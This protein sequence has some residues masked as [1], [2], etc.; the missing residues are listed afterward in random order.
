MSRTGAMKMDFSMNIGYYFRGGLWRNNVKEVIFQNA[1]CNQ[2][3]SYK[4]LATLNFT[5]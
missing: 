5:F 2:N 4:K 1:R 3:L